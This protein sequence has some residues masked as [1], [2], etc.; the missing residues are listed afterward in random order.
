[1]DNQLYRSQVFRTEIEAQ[2]VYR[3]LGISLGV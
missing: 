2:E 3:Q 1:M